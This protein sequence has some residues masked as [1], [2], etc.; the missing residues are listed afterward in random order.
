MSFSREGDVMRYMLLSILL[1][2]PVLL[3]QEPAPAQTPLPTFRS[4]ASDLVVLPVTVTDKGGRLLTD[5]P[6]EHF[7]IWDEGRRQDIAA[8]TSEDIPVSIAMVIDDSG[9]MRQKLGEVVAATLSFARWS[10]PEDELIVVE[11]NDVVR[12]AL[13]GRRLTAGDLPALGEALHTLR[14]D[15]QTALYDALMDG[16]GHL[17]ESGHARRILVLVSDG[18][19]NAS[20]ATVQE[21]LSRAIRSNVTIYAIG[22]FDDQ[23]RDSNPGVLKQ[24]AETTGGERFLPKSPGPLMTACE[25]IAREIRNSYTIGYEPPDR[26]GRYHR[27]RVDVSVAGRRGLRVK[28]RP[29][30]VA[31]EGAAR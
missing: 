25:Q 23:A 11:F 21:V 2:C 6:R 14:P 4:S 31:A 22:L 7:T 17:E 12:D 30:Y 9:S 3:A 18:G 13:E 16:I 10:H 15:G 20:R 5:L 28:T 29:G 8:F 24:L 27:L 19:D 1:T 26:D